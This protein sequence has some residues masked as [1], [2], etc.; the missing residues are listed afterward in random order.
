M[1][2]AKRNFLD[3]RSCFGYHADIHLWPEEMDAGAHALPDELEE[4]LRIV[5]PDW[6]QVDSKGHPGVTSYFSKVP[7]ATVGNLKHDAVAAWREAT[8]RLGLPLICHYSGYIDLAATLK[9]PEWRAVIPKDNWWRTQEE[10]FRS[11]WMCPRSAYWDRLM[12]PQLLELVNDYH[13]DGFWTDGDIW[14]FHGCWCPVCRAEFTRRTGIEDIPEKPDDPHHD[15]WWQFQYESALENIA[16]C[17]DAVHAANPNAKFCS[18]WLDTIKYPLPPKFQN[19]KVDWLSGDTPPVWPLEKGY[20]NLRTEALW[21]ACRGKYWDLMSWAMLGDPNYYPK[22]L[23]MLFQ[24]AAHVLAGGGRYIYCENVGGVRTSQ[25]VNWRLKRLAK[26]GDF[27]R[28]LAPFCR[29]AELVHEVALLSLENSPWD[30]DSVGRE[31][32]DALGPVMDCLMACHY[33]LDIM[34]D[35][36][37]LPQLPKFKAVVVGQDIAPVKATVDALK[38]YVENGGA[39]LLCG[40]RPMKAFGLD[41]LG[42]ARMDVETKSPLAGSQWNGEL[43]KNDMPLYFISDSEDGVFPV[44][45]RTWGLVREVDTSIAEPLEHI[46]DGFIKENSKTDCPAAVLTRRGRGTVISIPCDYFTAYERHYYLPEARK[47]IARLMK[48]L[49]P[50]RDIEVQ[51]P[52]VIDVILRKKNGCLLVHL[53]NRSTGS[54]T[55]PAKKAIDEIPPVGPVTVTFRLHK[56]PV[57]A[58]L[59]P[60]DTPL[61]IEWDSQAKTATVTVPSVRIHSTVRL[62]QA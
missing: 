39:L 57:Q 33:N 46:Y 31:T 38:S 2:K 44:S 60:E 25:Q 34:E 28:K 12:I 52:T 13:V 53:L 10:S 9:H 27:V 42:V 49:I 61:A 45:S 36:R 24:E 3:E 59:L 37:L 14:A 40:T 41:Y 21:I 17:A 48:R 6:V 56:S 7:D 1:E 30:N 54:A 32:E 47:F 23:D 8:D 4:S 29:G 22:P 20:A 50:V 11:H 51:A 16:K 43:K 19:M 5:T 15:E 55:A 35:N 58:T 18:N 62:Q 26:V